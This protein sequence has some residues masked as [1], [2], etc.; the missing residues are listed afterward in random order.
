MKKVLITGATGF[1]GQHLTN[2]LASLN[3]FEIYGTTQSDQ[4]SHKQGNVKLEKVDLSD[5]DSVLTM[6]DRIKPDFI[7]HLAALTSPAE[8]FNNPTPAVLGNIGMQMNLMNAMRKAN[9][10]NSRILIVS[11]GEVYGLIK[12]EDLPIDE[13][14]PFKPANPYAVSKVAQDFLGLQYYLSYKMDIVRVRPFNHTGP[15]QSSGFAIPSFARQIALIEKGEQEPVIKVGNL[16]SARDFTDV[17]DI[18]IG[19]KLLMEKGQIG[20]VYNIGSGKSITI[21]NMLDMLLSFSE[22]KVEVVE[23]SGK[24]RP[25]D[26]PNIYSNYSKLNTLTGWTPEIP[27]EQTLKDTLDYWR[28]IV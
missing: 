22:I 19:Y 2:Y 3:Q 16:L 1:V 21:K 26:T 24:V 14:T 6:I 8:S 12:T 13:D 28:S 23:D 4:S 9:L 20:D 10:I 17:R 25:L 11:S 18:V 7:Y 15:G 5:F 27:I